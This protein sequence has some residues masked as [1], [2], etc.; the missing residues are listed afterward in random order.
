MQKKNLVFVTFLLGAL[1]SVGAAFDALAHGSQPNVPVTSIL[2]DT[3]VVTAGTNYQIQDDGLGSYFN[4]VASLS[5]IL[6]GSSG[7]WILDT[8]SSSSRSIL[9]DLRQ[10]VPNSGASP[11]F[12]WELLPA[13]IISKCSEAL[14]GSFPAMALNQTL[15]C[16]TAVSFQYGGN[17]YGLMMASGPN[18]DINYAETNNPLVTC[19]SVNGSKQCDKWALLPIQQ[20]DRTIKNIARLRKALKGN[21]NFA[22]LGD[23][24]VSF[25]IEATNP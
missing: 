8:T 1:V 11:P 12:A 15:S 5:S 9:I 22:F 3:G 20:P 7:D 18:S 10:P 21:N 17:S 23:Y 19:T 4:G 13:R 24:Y 16:P 25:S 14:T 2:N 6:Q